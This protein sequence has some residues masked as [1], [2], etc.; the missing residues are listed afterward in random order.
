MCVFLPCALLSGVPFSLS[1]RSIQTK[2]CLCPII[3][4]MHICDLFAQRLCVACVRRMCSEVL[5]HC[6]TV[7][8]FCV[9][10]LSTPQEHRQPCCY[11]VNMHFGE[12]CHML[13][14]SI[15]VE[16]M[17]DGSAC[18]SSP[19]TPFNLVFSY[20]FDQWKAISVF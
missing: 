10:E 4:I 18:G 11:P 3:L 1:S 12:G 5:G 2:R 19:I 6:V 13:R 8:A 20:C 16:A 14:L 7:T 17:F 15:L 9:A